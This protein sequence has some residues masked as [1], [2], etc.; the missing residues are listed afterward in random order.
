MPTYNRDWEVQAEKRG[1]SAGIDQQAGFF[2]Q[3]WRQTVWQEVVPAGRC[4]NSAGIDPW[5]CHVGVEAGGLSTE[6]AL[7]RFRV[8][9]R[10]IEILV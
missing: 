8:V 2:P 1:C 3:G 9:D 6:A 4:C 5:F 7:E 10:G